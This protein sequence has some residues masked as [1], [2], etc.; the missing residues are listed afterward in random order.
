MR[1]RFRALF[2]SDWR[3]RFACHAIGIVL[4]LLGCSN[5][6]RHRIMHV[7]FEYPQETASP[8]P[9]PLDRPHPVDVYAES[10]F[11]GGR[12]LSR[13]EPFVTRQCQTCHARNQSQSPRS[14]FLANCRE[15]HKDYFGN[16]R[17]TH[18]PVA[19]R[20]CLACHNMHV[21]QF[22]SLLHEPQETLCISCHAAQY[23]NDALTSYHRAISKSACTSC[24]DPHFADNP[25][26]LKIAALRG[27]QSTNV[28]EPRSD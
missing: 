13:H 12:L 27:P 26:L 10:F 9:A 4:I 18:G 7:L 20:D 11:A 2:F 17:Y 16:P 8:S 5:E 14:D 3:L 23:S 19:S 22:N 24:H 1:H 21:S 6:A 15:C 28:E 25:S